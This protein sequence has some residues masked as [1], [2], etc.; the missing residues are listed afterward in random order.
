MLGTRQPRALR[1]AL[2]AVKTLRRVV[3]QQ[4]S[5][6][7]AF[8]TSKA[9]LPAYE[10]GTLRDLCSGTLR[11][12]H[13]YA[14]VIEALAPPTASDDARLLMAATLYEAEHMRSSRA[15]LLAR[16]DAC[17][18]AL[19]LP[20]GRQAV[21]EVCTRAL[22]LTPQD[23][24]A[25]HTA[26]SALSL[27]EWLHTRLAAETP[28]PSYGELLL[29]RPDFLAMCAMPSACMLPLSRAGRVEPAPTPKP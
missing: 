29:R 10:H 16:A 5:L 4:Q 21:Q 1:T 6:E 25:L 14:A 11:H 24:Q 26:A 23:Q 20:E 22:A 3:W 8:G 9:A 12:W 15:K 28:L 13:F 27:P 2:Q 18:E 7:T 19:Q 17:C